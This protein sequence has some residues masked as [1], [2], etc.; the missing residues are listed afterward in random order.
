[1][2]VSYLEQKN[3]S[4]KKSERKNSSRRQE[5]INIKIQHSCSC[6]S[7]FN[8]KEGVFIFTEECLSTV[9][10]INIYLKMDSQPEV[11]TWHPFQC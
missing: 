2:R 5:L 4:E 7:S 8:F 3:T 6:N 10:W 11:F 9:T 1:M